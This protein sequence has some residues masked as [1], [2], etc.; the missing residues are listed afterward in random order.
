MLTLL[1][2][3]ILTIVNYFPK[4]Q[5]NKYPQPTPPSLKEYYGTN[6]CVAADAFVRPRSPAET[7]EEKPTNSHRA[8]ART[9]NIFRKHF[10]TL[11]R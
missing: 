6:A 8:E 5:H 3:N 1:Y 11:K 2:P 10:E 7:A 4:Q 9:P